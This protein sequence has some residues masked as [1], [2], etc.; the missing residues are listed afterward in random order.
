MQ[1][2]MIWNNIF[3]IRFEKTK[4]FLNFYIWYK[5]GQTNVRMVDNA[6]IESIGG[7]EGLKLKLEEWGYDGKTPLTCLDFGDCLE[8]KHVL[9]DV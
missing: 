6:Y 5:D 9:E 1:N 3:D 7:E 8:I 2:M 4:Q